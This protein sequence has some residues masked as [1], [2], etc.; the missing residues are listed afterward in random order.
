MT[1]A[2][3]TYIEPGKTSIQRNTPRQ[4]PSGTWVL[5]WSVR[6]HS[7]RL[8]E[9]RTQAD[10]RTRVRAR[11]ERTAAKLLATGGNSVKW[12][13]STP[14]ERF[15]DQVTIPS[16]TS[17]G[18][19]PSTTTLYTTAATRLKTQLRGLS[20]ADAST[21]A[22]AT[23]ALQGIS[24]EFGVGAARNAKKVYAGHFIAPLLA[25]SLISASPIR[26]EHPIN[27]TAGAKPT[28]KAPRG[29]RE[30]TTAH[31]HQVVGWLL[32]ADPAD[33]PPPKRGR[34]THDDMIA[35]RKNA[36]DQA[37]LQ[38]ATGLRLQETVGQHWA[39]VDDRGDDGMW[40]TTTFPKPVRVGGE[41]VRKPRTIPLLLPEVAD[42]LRGRRRDANSMWVLPA[43]TN[44]AKTWTASAAKEAMAT[45]Y[46]D[47]ADALDIEPLRTL[48]SHCWRT[49]IN[50]ELID[51]GVDAEDRIA[52]LGHSAD[53]NAASYTDGRS[54][55]AITGLIGNL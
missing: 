4:L 14:A 10:T 27:I 50:R 34:W 23:N 55:T 3:R 6:L 2:P 1:K 21:F 42:H 15:I 37:L 13:P 53:V 7:G 49:V 31:W 35:V 22:E 38:C 17:A 51:R 40:L 29:S 48:R 39:D 18:L 47:M 36:I 16:I 24:A 54:L 26:K 25:H 44:P 8:V 41:S 32:A 52:Y 43:P 20:V 19:A 11:A 30:L 45:L 5:D 28:T 9:K 33:T 46:V 12:T